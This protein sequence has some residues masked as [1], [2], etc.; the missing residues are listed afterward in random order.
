MLIGIISDTHDDWKAIAAA[1]KK[2]RE[3][4][5]ELVIH[6][7]DWTSP[8]SMLKLRRAVGPGVR[9][10]TVFGNNDGD[11][12]L[13]ALRSAKAE[14]EILGEAG[15]VEADGLKIGI[16]HGTS[17][18]LVEAMAK[19]GLFDVVIYG[20]TH[21]PHVERHNG[22]LVINPGEACGCASERKTA[23]L[24]NTETRE[25]ELAEL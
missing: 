11:R 25:V 12:Y 13:F 20:H 18:I 10:A 22:V 21:K 5:V 4:G 7:G 2:F 14:V 19:S 23:A 24:L 6:A 16:Y 9:I 3:A 8:F 15:V 17:P 1:G